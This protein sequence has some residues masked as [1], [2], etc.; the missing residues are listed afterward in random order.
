M[1]SI[2]IL[3]SINYAEESVTTNKFIMGACSWREAHICNR[4]I[5]FYGFFFII[6]TT[7]GENQ[8]HKN[9]FISRKTNSTRSGIIRY[10]TIALANRFVGN[11]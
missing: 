2:F 11:V 8:Q 6:N 10:S 4:F 7:E 9:N 1:L 5:C 3:S